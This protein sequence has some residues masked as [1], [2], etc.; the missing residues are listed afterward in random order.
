MDGRD[1]RQLLHGPDSRWHDVAPDE[2]GD[3]WAVVATLIE[4]CKLSDVKSYAHLADVLREIVNGHLNSAIDELL[5]WAYATA[6][7]LKA[8]AWGHRLLYNTGARA[9][10]MI[11]MRWGNAVLEGQPATHLHGKGRKDRSAARRP[12]RPRRALSACSRLRGH[13]QARNFFGVVGYLQKQTDVEL[14]VA[15]GSR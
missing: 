2:G 11:G 15:D 4:N 10:E 9:S 12:T 8:V 13:P 14:H 5:P 7:P 6:E 1:R 3:N